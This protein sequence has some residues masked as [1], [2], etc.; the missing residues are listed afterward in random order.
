AVGGG[1]IGGTLGLLAGVGALVIPGIG[2]IVAAGTIA[3]TLAGAGIGAAAGGLLGALAGMG[4]PEEEAR[5]F[6]QGVQSGGILV[7]VRA[8]A[9]A[10]E[11]RQIL[12][13]EGA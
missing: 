4:I 10:A 3:S 12:A 2:P 6:E 9:R 5:H 8:G 7:T 1:L 11:A 13:G